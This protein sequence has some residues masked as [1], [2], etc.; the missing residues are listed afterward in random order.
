MV[1]RL[2]LPQF[3]RQ[4]L[5]AASDARH[6]CGQQLWCGGFAIWVLTVVFRL[7]DILVLS[8]S[9]FLTTEVV[10]PC[11]AKDHGSDDEQC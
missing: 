7:R 10:G 4:P 6:V 1:F 11:E 3:L 2:I 8:F 9:S 5:I